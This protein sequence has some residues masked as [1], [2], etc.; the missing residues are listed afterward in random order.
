MSPTA[1][2][3]SDNNKVL[4]HSA[5]SNS[6]IIRLE[7]SLQRSKPP[8]LRSWV[9]E[10]WFTKNQSL[11]LLPRRYQK[12]NFMYCGLTA[13]FSKIS[14]CRI[15]WRC[16]AEVSVLHHMNVTDN[17]LFIASNKETA[18]QPL[19]LASS[20]PN[21]TVINRATWNEQGSKHYIKIKI[22]AD[23]ARNRFSRSKKFYLTCLILLVLGK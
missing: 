7:T 20:F 6:G 21:L 14:A 8:F 4:S 16:Q 23:F 9:Y 13:T 22:C 17:S 12:V 11:V 5:L 10:S 3:I 19:A 1:Y 2:F 15:S 18:L